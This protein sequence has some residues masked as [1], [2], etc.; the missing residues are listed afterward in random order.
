MRI[1]MNQEPL[2]LAPDVIL[3]NNL[4]RWSD[5]NPSHYMTDYSAI[6]ETRHAVSPFPYDPDINHKIILWYVCELSPKFFN[7]LIETLIFPGRET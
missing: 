4:E 6:G 1:I 7:L 2:G 3:P 5:L